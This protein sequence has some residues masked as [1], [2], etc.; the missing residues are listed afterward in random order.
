MCN[1][2]HIRQSTNRIDWECI[3]WTIFSSSTSFAIISCKSS[4]RNMPTQ[5]AARLFPHLINNNNLLFRKFLSKFK[6]RLDFNQLQLAWNLATFGLSIS[7]SIL[8]SN[9]INLTINLATY[10]LTINCYGI[11]RTELKSAW[12]STNWIPWSKSM[13]KAKREANEAPNRVE[14]CQ[15]DLVAAS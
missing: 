13:I 8:Q 10:G 9:Q 4:T 12:T 15:P 2:L 11:N 6:F 5:I 3:S 7:E 14:L 1:L